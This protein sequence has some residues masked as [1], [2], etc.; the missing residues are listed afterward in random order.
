MKRLGM[1]GEEV[2]ALCGLKFGKTN[3]RDLTTGQ[4]S[5]LAA[6]LEEWEA[7]QMGGK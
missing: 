4:I 1:T 7:E 6:H 2:S 3:S 5:E